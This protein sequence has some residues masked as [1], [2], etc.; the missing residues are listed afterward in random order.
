MPKETNYQKVL[1]LRTH[2]VLGSCWALG[3][4]S[5]VIGKAALG[6]NQVHVCAQLQS[7]RP[8]RLPSRRSALWVI[9]L[10]ASWS[11]CGSTH[12]GL[13]RGCWEAGSSGLSCGTLPSCL[14][15]LAIWLTLLGW[16]A[17]ERTGVEVEGS[18]QVEK[19]FRYNFTFLCLKIVK[20]HNINILLNYLVIIIVV[21]SESRKKKY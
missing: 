15:L 10:S 13:K 3:L 21:T 2:E 4:L 8:G 6:E 18:K 11:P 9:T 1:S 16:T 19:H 12:L 7:G 5:L 14:R 17:E 20:L